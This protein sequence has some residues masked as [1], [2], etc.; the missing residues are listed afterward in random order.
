MRW[1]RWVLALTLIAAAC[2]ST[3]ETPATTATGEPAPTT[4]PALGAGGLSTT[5]ATPASPPA[6]QSTTTLSSPYSGC[7]E[8]RS[9]IAAVDY[10]I[11]GNH[12]AGRIREV[13]DQKWLEYPSPNDD[14]VHLTLDEALEIGKFLHASATAQVIREIMEEVAQEPPPQPVQ[15]EHA[16]L[17]KALY[18]YAES[19]TNY[20]VEIFPTKV[21][22]DQVGSQPSPDQLAHAGEQVDAAYFQVE[23]AWNLAVLLCP[24]PQM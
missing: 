3:A 10:I 24:D 9:R 6:T 17:V 19:E 8:Y 5:T 18:G 12:E 4:V 1:A 21:Y 23:N 14:G 22:G 15:A 2:T 7:A 20:A 16:E 13:L 11:W